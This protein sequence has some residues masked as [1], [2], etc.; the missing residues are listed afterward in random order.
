MGNT[1]VNA[2]SPAKK[3]L[4]IVLSVL[5]A[6][7]VIGL[8]VFNAL[9]QNGFFLRHTVAMES[10]NY[11]VT[12]TEM[13][14]FFSTNYT[15]EMSSK[16]SLYQYYGLDTSKSLKSQN[17]PGGGTWYDYFMQS[18]TVPA[19]KNVLTLCE[20]A[21][22]EGMK[23]E[24][25]DYE[26]IDALIEDMETSAKN[27]GVSLSYYINNYY[28]IGVKVSDIRNAM[29][30]SRLAMNYYN[31]IMDSYVHTDADLEAYYGEHKDDFDKIDY[32]T[33]TFDVKDVK[34]EDADTSTDTT[35]DTAA[36]EGTDTAEENKDAP[37]LEIINAYANEL[38][39]LHTA[40][41]FKAYVENYLNTVVYANEEGEEKEEL[42]EKA[43]AELEKK[44]VTYS[45][46]GDEA[47]KALFKEAN[48]GFTTIGDKESEGKYQVYLLTAPAYRLE[49]TTKNARVISLSGDDV[50]AKVDDIREGL[51]GASD[52]DAEFAKLAEEYGEQNGGLYENLAR[53]VFDDEELNAW[54]FDEVR[55]A[56]DYDL[57]SHKHEE[58]STS[59]SHN[60]MV[61]YV[62]DGQ[63]KWKNDADNAMKNEKYEEH[64]KGLEEAHGGD[65]ITVNLEDIYKIPTN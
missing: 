58:S 33:Y 50:T 59:T 20:S 54:L 46:N 35:A 17:Y 52:V 47:L 60:Y 53:G 8:C 61:M 32:L 2:Q 27:N 6:V 5:F 12:N 44:E 51:K 45:E 13:S 57:F 43:M 30:I 56:G 23:L 15:A 18:V 10:E 11:K 42:V 48:A 1:K 34:P 16:S 7:A 31:K 36:A 9:S 41:E 55:T 65:K 14:Y 37:Y 24:D 28:G 26:A 38:G 21:R 4:I 29:E 49:Y 25:A 62:S 40:E 22:A 39:T 19:V 63:T 64:Y 3:I